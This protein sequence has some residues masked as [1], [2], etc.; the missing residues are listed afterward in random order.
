M[1]DATFDL[2]PLDAT[3]GAIVR[4]VELRA[5][6]DDTWEALHA[7]W[8]D[9]ALLIFPG[10]FLT[11]DEQNGFAERFGDIEFYATPISNIDKDGNVH[12]EAGDDVVKSLRG[13][14]GWHHDSTYMPLQAKGAVFTAEIVP[15]DGAATGWAD[16]R[17][18]YEA[19]DDDTRALVAGLRAYHSLFYSQGRAGYLPSKQNERGGYDMYG[20]HELEPSLRPLVKVHPE[21]GRPNLLIGRHAYG[22]VGMD[23]EESERLLDRLN[24]EAC[25]PPRVYHHQWEVGDAVVWDNRRLMHRGTPFDMTEPRRMWH[26]RIAGDRPSELAVNHLEDAEAVSARP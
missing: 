5:L 9:Y 7:T 25:Q 10:Q 18:A 12:S 20:Y 22:I 2:E 21:T 8:L 17:A 6:D 4:G 15:S 23:A 24:E 3:F 19:L 1:A 14:E 13:N 26:T 16:M 11:R